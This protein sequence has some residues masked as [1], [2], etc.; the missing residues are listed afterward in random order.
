MAGGPGQR[1]WTQGFPGE[2]AS[3][4]AWL[5]RDFWNRVLTWRMV[6]FRLAPG[7]AVPRLRQDGDERRSRCGNDR[8][9]I[10]TAKMEARGVGQPAQGARSECRGSAG[11]TLGGVASRQQRATPKPACTPPPCSGQASLE[12][13]RGRRRTP[14]RWARLRLPLRGSTWRG[15]LTRAGTEPRCAPSAQGCAREPPPGLLCRT[16]G[17]RG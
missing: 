4:E 5:Q 13:R 14:A 12:A 7:T 8:W 16:V 3:W 15:Q 11:A 10:E 2:A 1:E 9:R 17:Q 6:S